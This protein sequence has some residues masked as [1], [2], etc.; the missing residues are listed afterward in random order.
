M[1]HLLLY[2]CSL[3]SVYNQ[4]WWG[5]SNL[6]Y[7][8]FHTQVAGDTKSLDVSS[9]AQRATWWNFY[10]FICF[11][12]VPYIDVVSVKHRLGCRGRRV[13]V[14]VSLHLQNLSL[15]DSLD[16]VYLL[17][18]VVLHVFFSPTII[19]DTH[20]YTSRSPFADLG[21]PVTSASSQRCHRDCAEMTLEF[22]LNVFH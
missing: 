7:E 16:K 4:R 12:S 13:F 2:E 15:C 3:R 18:F 20:F 1:I 6:Y 8:L 9:R 10:Y 22:F 11:E 17:I 21:R 19:G 14:P 5:H